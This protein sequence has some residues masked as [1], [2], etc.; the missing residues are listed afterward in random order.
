[1]GYSGITGKESQQTTVVFKSEKGS[2]KNRQKQIVPH[3]REKKRILRIRAQA[4]RI[5][6]WNFSIENLTTDTAKTDELYRNESTGFFPHVFNS[7]IDSHDTKR[8]KKMISI[9]LVC[10]AVNIFDGY[11]N[12]LSVGFSNI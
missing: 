6:N 11:N 7:L 12:I 8:K 9:C 10:S 1:M 4:T 2:N 5:N 3:V